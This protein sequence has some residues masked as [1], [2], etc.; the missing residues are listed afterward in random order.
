MSAKELFQQAR[1]AHSSQDLDK[2]KQFYE[3]VIS[4]YS[5]SEEADLSRAHL[6]NIQHPTESGSESPD[7]TAS[8]AGA[9]QG[10]VITDIQMP[11]WSMVAFMVKW[12]IATIPAIIILF[13]I[14]SALIGVSGGILGGLLR[15]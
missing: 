11:F 7:A 15:W 12:V 3:R 2:A 6:Y 8:V 10:V 9:A 13:I 4:E 5:T 14:V 1:E